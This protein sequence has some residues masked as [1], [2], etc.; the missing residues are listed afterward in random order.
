MPDGSINVKITAEARGFTSTVNQAKAALDQLAA[1]VHAQTAGLGQ[2]TSAMQQLAAAVQAQQGG[3]AQLTSTLTQNTAA[4]HTHATAVQ[5]QN[6]GWHRRS[7]R[8]SRSFPRIPRT[9]LRCTTR[10]RRIPGL[11]GRST[12]PAN[13]S[14]ACYRR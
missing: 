5:A 11:D 10:P 13:P 6:A 14:R 3:L 8:C 1:A 4:Q 7:V 9:P 12:R 2:T